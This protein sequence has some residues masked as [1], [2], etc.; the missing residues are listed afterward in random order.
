MLFDLRSTST[1]CHDVF[2]APFKQGCYQLRDA[3]TGKRADAIAQNVF[4]GSPLKKD[5]SLSERVSAAVVGI[6]L[7]IPIVNAIAY[8]IL[9]IASSD[10]LYSKESEALERVTP[11]NTSVSH[12]EMIAR[13]WEALD[14]LTEIDEMVRPGQQALSEISRHFELNNYVLQFDLD[15][16]L[17][18]YRNR[19]APTKLYDFMDWAGIPNNYQRDAFRSAI[20]P[21][22]QGGIR[23]D[24]QHLSVQTSFGYLAEFFVQRQ[25]Q[26]EA[27]TPEE[28]ALKEQFARVYATIIDA[29][30][31]CID[32]MLTQLQE[33][34]LDL[35][36]E[37]DA[38]GGDN[39]IQIQLINRVGLV[40]CQ[41]RSRLL[42]MILA[43]QNG[44]ETH[45]ADLQ[46]V[47]TQQAA[48]ALGMQGGIFAAGA[49]FR[50]AVS[51]TDV[52]VNRAVSS[53]LDEYKPL[54]YLLN[55]LSGVA[56][57]HRT[58]RCELLKWA[59]DFF[60]SDLETD[61]MGNPAPANLPDGSVAPH[62]DARLSEDLE[63]N[64]M[65]AFEGG[66]IRI[67]GVALLLE[68]LGIIDQSG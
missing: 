53:F 8:A 30:R 65:S 58:L 16:L 23:R 5:L 21:F 7:I 1:Q 25:A 63:P 2:V 32:Q 67:Q 43:R 62:M 44:D 41:Y 36:S 20:D 57:N 39:P 46:R 33:L 26:V 61:S 28:A 48:E 49:R 52:R 68:K 38:E 64:A 10:L 24:A 55:D 19:H 45:M 6:L 27:G 11:I 15:R 13:K 29:N 12:E 60:G 66:T 17:E 31:G 42:T 3:F 18:R 34:V 37:G 47:V 9:K 50:H 4:T 22:S 56:G 54:E 14:R 40:L 35:I 51:N 59:T